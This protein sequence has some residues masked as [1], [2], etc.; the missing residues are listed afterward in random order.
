MP[1]VRLLLVRHGEST[2]NAEGRWQGQADPP[3]TDRGRAQARA[4]A[5]GLPPTVDALWASD[6]ERARV[7]AELLGAAVGSD[8]VVDAGFRERDAGAFSG[9]TRPEIHQRHP[10]LLPDDP[11]RPPGT[12]A[13]GLIEPPGWEPE[14]EL[15]GRAWAAIGRVAAALDATGPDTAT[16]VVVTHSGLIYSVE[17]PLTGDRAR[18]ANLEGRWLHRVGGRWEIGPRHLLLDPAAVTVTRPD[19]L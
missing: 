16:A 12:E 13:D 4:A 7:T 17:R 3:L 14:A 15:N 8:V 2:W 5:A 11:A 19:A 18:I 1:D 6:L 9:L 10:G